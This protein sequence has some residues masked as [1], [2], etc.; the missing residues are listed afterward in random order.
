MGKGEVR[1]RKTPVRLLSH[2][3][4]V[5]YSTGCKE[6]SCLIGWWGNK[7]LKWGKSFAW[8][9]FGRFFA[10]ED[11]AFTL[12][13]MVSTGAV[14]GNAHRPVATPCRRRSDD[15]NCKDNFAAFT[16]KRRLKSIWLQRH[17]D[18]K[19]HQEAMRF[20]EG[21]ITEDD[22]SA[23]PS[24]QDF[25]SALKNMKKGNSMRNGGVASD[26]AS[27]VHWCLSESLL[28]VWRRKMSQADHALPSERR[29]EG[30]SF[31]SAG[32]HCSWGFQA[33][34]FHYSYFDNR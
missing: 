21:H 5:K 1:S 16:L 29:K 6:Q 17:R 32:R 20:L 4:A 27:L 28:Q 13:C 33:H 11:A 23:A 34:A 7:G 9:R 30:E 10:S 14:L 31:E 12:S 15:D 2:G 8:L 24:L 19:K 18:S 26:T 3:S 25:A 22:K